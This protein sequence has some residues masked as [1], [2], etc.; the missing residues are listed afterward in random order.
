MSTNMAAT[1]HSFSTSFIWHIH[2]HQSSNQAHPSPITHASYINMGFLTQVMLSDRSHYSLAFCSG[3]S[4]VAC[5]LQ[6]HIPA[7]DKKAFNYFTQCPAVQHQACL[8]RSEN[9]H[10]LYMYCTVGIRH[11]AWGVY[12]YDKQVCVWPVVMGI[13]LLFS[14]PAHLTQLTKKIR[15]FQVLNGSFWSRRFWPKIIMWT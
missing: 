11:T 9:F 15:L 8:G 5:W 2:N 12:Y 4:S 1:D 7:L 14:E 3:T 13:L 10:L 6:M